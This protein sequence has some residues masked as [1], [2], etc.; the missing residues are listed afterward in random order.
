MLGLQLHEAQLQLTKS[1]TIKQRNH[2]VT[3]YMIL[4]YKGSTWPAVISLI[5][6]N[7]TKFQGECTEHQTLELDNTGAH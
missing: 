7:S 5:N 2:M 3:L 6:S 4:H 1:I